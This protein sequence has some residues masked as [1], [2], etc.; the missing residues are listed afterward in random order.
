MSV[1]TMP[2][3]KE[4]SVLSVGSAPGADPQLTF[5][6]ALICHKNAA[7]Q[8]LPEMDQGIITHAESSYCSTSTTDAH[9]TSYSNDHHTMVDIC[10]L[11]LEMNAV[12]SSLTIHVA[13]VCKA[14]QK[15]PMA[16]IWP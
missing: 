14:A 3:S 2:K 5:S 16:Q 4:T 8:G 1:L 10:L 6:Q 13:H 12:P 15:L 9:A 11:L 7:P